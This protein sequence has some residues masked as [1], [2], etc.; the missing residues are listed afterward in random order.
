[1]IEIL[2]IVCTSCICNLYYLSMIALCRDLRECSISPSAWG[3]GEQ[4]WVEGPVFLMSSSFGCR[5]FLGVFP[6]IFQVSSTT[7]GRFNWFLPFSAFFCPFLPLCA[8]VSGCLKGSQ[9]QWHR[10]RCWRGYSGWN[11]SEGRLW[12]ADLGDKVREASLT[13]F[14]RRMLK[15][16]PKRRF[17][18]W[19]R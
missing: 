6:E 7:V 19:M 1:M 12:L 13:W 10:C 3:R 2:Y 8:T 14:G 5:S 4:V 9:K 16:E 11:T 17:C 15:M 18:I